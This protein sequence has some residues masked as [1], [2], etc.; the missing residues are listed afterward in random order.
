MLDIIFILDE[1]L[2]MEEY[3]NSYIQ[4]INEFINEQKQTNPTA[5]FTMIKFNNEVNVL[6]VDSKI[7]TLPVFTCDNY[8]PS[9]ITS[10]YDAI[11]YGID[12]KHNSIQNV[13]MIIITDG[14]D[15]N[16]SKYNINTIGT[17]INYLKQCG[18]EFLYIASSHNS[19]IV[20]KKIGI[21]TCLSY[22]ETDKSISQIAHAC[23][24]AIGHA[25]H[26]WTGILNKYVTHEMPTDI[27]NLMD[28]FNNIKI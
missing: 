2:S 12:L 19:Q 1:S 4:G 10:L 5:N 18:W 21:E 3:I 13:I 17:K 9:G 22:S 26:K 8:K 7:H 28:D 20:G 6:C 23:S 25:L 11:G 14:D 15:N 27:R 24:V 16:S